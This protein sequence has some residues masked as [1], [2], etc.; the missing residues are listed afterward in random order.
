MR[1]VLITIVES[2]TDICRLKQRLDRVFPFANWNFDLEDGDNIPRI[3]IKI[4]NCTIN[5][6]TPD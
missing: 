4:R 2:E 3:E 6:H 5:Y 1:Y